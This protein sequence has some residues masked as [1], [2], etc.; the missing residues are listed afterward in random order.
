MLATIAADSEGAA[1][2]VS[3]PSAP[4]GSSS[5]ATTMEPPLESMLLSLTHI[6]T[7]NGCLERALRWL[8]HW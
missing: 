1:G 8:M 5:W 6:L 7:S 2:A 3:W 4:Q